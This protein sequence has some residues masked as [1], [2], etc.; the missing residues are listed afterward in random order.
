MIHGRYRVLNRLTPLYRA[1][2]SGRVII[3]N[4]SNM[5]IPAAVCNSPQLVESSTLAL[6]YCNLLV[7]N[8][9][10]LERGGI[11]LR[12]IRGFRNAGKHLRYD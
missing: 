12:R 1:P 10:L 7:A 2:F 9:I 5:C 11:L 6:K 8:S 3:R 4:N